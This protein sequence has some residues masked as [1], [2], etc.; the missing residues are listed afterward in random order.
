M[1]LVNFIHIN[2]W[3]IYISFSNLQVKKI[4]TTVI[5]NEHTVHWN[6]CCHW[7]HL[8]SLTLIFSAP[9]SKIYDYTL[10]FLQTIFKSFY[11]QGVLKLK[12]HINVLSIFLHHLMDLFVLWFYFERNNWF[13][14]LFL[15]KSNK[16]ILLAVNFLIVSYSSISLFSQI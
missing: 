10:N 14:A 9:C 7:A 1:E 11:L 13:K 16:E 6:L 4:G 15:K 3:S 2:A 5:L 12:V 8:S